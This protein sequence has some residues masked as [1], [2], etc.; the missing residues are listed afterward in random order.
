MTTSEYCKKFVSKNVIRYH[1]YKKNVL[2]YQV[3]IFVTVTTRMNILTTLFII[4]I[5]Y[6]KG[7]IMDIIMINENVRIRFIDQL[8]S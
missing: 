5:T 7:Q 2:K 6:Y 4:F 1:F 8:K 3:H